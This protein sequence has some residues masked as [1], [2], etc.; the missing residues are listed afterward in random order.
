MSVSQSKLFIDPK[1]DYPIHDL[2]LSFAEY[3]K[4]CKQIITKGR[5]ELDNESIIDANTPYELQPP[6]D[7]KNKYG[8]LLVH[9][10]FDS[11]FVMR[12]IGHQLC[13][14][15]LLVRSILLPGHGTVPG[16]LLGVDYHDWLQAVNYGVATFTNEVEKIFLVGFSTGASLALHHAAQ[17]PSI[18][19][20]IMIS[21]AVRILSPFACITNIPPKFSKKWQRANWFCIRAENDFARYQSIPFNAIYQ[22]YLLTQEI[23]HTGYKQWAK[24]PI[25]IALSEQD[26]VISSEANLSIFSHLQNPKNR[27]LL[28]SAKKQSN[29]DARITLRNSVYPELGAVNF[30]HITLPITP[31]NFHY[32]EQGNY[33][34]AS[35]TDLNKFIYGAYNRPRIYIDKMLYQFKLIN[36]RHRRLTYNPDFEFMASTVKNFIDSL[37]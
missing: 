2:H 14:Q 15:G 24:T 3:I 7:K 1:L 13:Q 28:Y 5:I 34:Y 19:G 31:T 10:L 22:L 9:G 11:P 30:S 37:L 26:E 32:G 20:V 18:A 27:M 21:P 4:K 12:D 25:Y 33:C 23:R 17:H 29:G 6:A 36:K 35:H 8:A 16:A